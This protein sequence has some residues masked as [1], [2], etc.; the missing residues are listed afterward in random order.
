M[1]D[2]SLDILMKV[3]LAV[4]GITVLALTWLRPM[5]LPEMIISH[6]IGLS[7]LGAVFAWSGLS[8]S[9]HGDREK[10][11]APVIVDIKTD[12]KHLLS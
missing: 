5:P 10:E 12:H 1:K 6:F 7:G 11:T 9:P 3:F 4:G 2:K 8:K